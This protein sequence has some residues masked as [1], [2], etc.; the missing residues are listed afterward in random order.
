MPGSTHPVGGKLDIAQLFDPGS[1]NIGDSFGN[2]QTSRRGC[3]QQ[4][5]RGAL[6][7]AHGF[8][9]IAVVADSGYGAISY[10]H[11]PGTNHLIAHYHATH[12][13]VTNGNQEAFIGDRRVFEHALS[14]IVNV[15]LGGNKRMSA[16]L[17]TL[18]SSVHFRRLA[19]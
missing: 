6:A 18:G 5:Y 2:R 4:R 14:G 11:L 1:G 19:E 17:I 8:S 16:S 9:A 3:I 10:W 12:R 7:H 13:A 15:Y